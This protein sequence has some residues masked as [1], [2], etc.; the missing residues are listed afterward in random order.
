[1]SH[2]VKSGWFK[3]I[4][5]FV[6]DIQSEHVSIGMT[7]MWRETSWGAHLCHIN[8][9]RHPATCLW[10]RDSAISTTRPPMSCG[11]FSHVFVMS[12]IY[13][14]QGCPD[15]AQ[16]HSDNHPKRLGHSRFICTRAL[17]LFI[18]ML[19]YFSVPIKP[20]VRVAAPETVLMS[21]K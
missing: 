13:Y 8:G 6:G 5:I 12:C 19:A 7:K 15:N 4:C 21:H 16:V 1:M 3:V 11:R 17:L 2:F 14:R 10:D 9:T 20:L 18:L